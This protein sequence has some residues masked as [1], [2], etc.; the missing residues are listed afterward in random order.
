M[1]FSGSSY[2]DVDGPLH[3]RM[4]NR[5][6]LRSNF[7]MHTCLAI[8]AQRFSTYGSW[9]AARIIR[10]PARHRRSQTSPHPQNT[11]YVGQKSEFSKR[12]KLL[13]SLPKFYSSQCISG[14]CSAVIHGE[15]H[16]KCPQMIVSS[17]SSSWLAHSCV[18]P[19][20]TAPLAGSK[21][22]PCNIVTARAYLGPQMLSCSWGSQERSSKCPG[23]APSRACQAAEV[24]GSSGKYVCQWY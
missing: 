7:E 15:L 22:C 14:V 11:G 2:L 19:A 5:H 23:T 21:H 10:E 12:F 17:Y 24:H 4:P 1:A 3:R 13:W 16:A 6:V 9:S 18:V 8:P 20:L